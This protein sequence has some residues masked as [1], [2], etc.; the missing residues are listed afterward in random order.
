MPADLRMRRAPHS[1]KL[2]LLDYCADT[3]LEV[4]DYV[5]GELISSKGRSTNHRDVAVPTDLLPGALALMT[6]VRPFLP[7]RC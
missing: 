7:A 4:L 6:E 5:R 2:L 3:R 1:L